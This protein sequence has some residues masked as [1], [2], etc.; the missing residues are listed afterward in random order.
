MTVTTITVAA[1][2]KVMAS[3]FKR[4]KEMA[5]LTFWPFLGREKVER[6]E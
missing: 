1:A 6:R 4:L 5:L 2:E 3:T